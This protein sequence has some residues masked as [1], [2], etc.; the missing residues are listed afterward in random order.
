MALSTRSRAASVPGINSYYCD[1][2]ALH[3]GQVQELRLPKSERTIE[4]TEVIMID[5]IGSCCCCTWNERR[6]QVLSRDKS[7]GY[8]GALSPGHDVEE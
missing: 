6:G 1:C 2:S 5:L 3:G 7:R 4:W 8:M